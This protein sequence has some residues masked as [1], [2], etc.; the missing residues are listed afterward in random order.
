[1]K[2]NTTKHYQRYCT[3]KS[4]RLFGQLNVKKRQEKPVPTAKRPGKDGLTTENLLGNT[5]PTLGKH[6]WEN[7]TNF[8]LRFQCG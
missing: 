4:N 3:E 5:R 1:M 8:P 6:Q 7:C 2:L